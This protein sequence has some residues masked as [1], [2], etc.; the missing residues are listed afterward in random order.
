MVVDEKGLIRAMKEAYKSKG[1]KVAMDESGG[2]ERVIL[3]AALWTV[4]INRSELPRKVLGLIAEH[5]GEIPEVNNAYQVRK[6][7]TQTEIFDMV[8]Q[9]VQD[10]RSGEKSR[11]I[12][13]KTSL[14]LD[15]YSIWQAATDLQVLKLD[16]ER[17][18]IMNWG[19]Y[20]VWLI[21]DDL[22]M[23]D[24]DVSRVYIRCSS[25]RSEDELE[26]LSHLAKIQWVA[27]DT[28]K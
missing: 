22:L 2:I 15:G 25:T 13:R 23:V 27:A 8:L 11:R 20:R 12:A 28:G 24:D 1:Y 9:N 6:K 16:P 5:V 3:S 7:D 26:K 17:E 14:V 10:F 21:G 18:E 4:V 19:R